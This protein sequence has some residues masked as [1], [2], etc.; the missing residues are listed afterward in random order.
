MTSDK[1]RTKRISV[2]LPV[3]VYLFDNK[4]KI[5]IGDPLAGCIKDFSPLGAALTVDT[6]LLNGKHLFYTCQDNPDIVLELAFELSGPEEIITVPAVPVWFDRDFDSD[7]KKFDVGL[8]FLANSRSPEI[9][10]LSKEACNDETML[11]SL[12]K[13][14]LQFSIF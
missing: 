14:F 1:R 10:T 5:R 8:K 9:K 7:K 3:K 12:W 4:G 11:V 2:E 6:I 13:K